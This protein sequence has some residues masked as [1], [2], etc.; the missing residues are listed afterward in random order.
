MKVLVTGGAGFIG[1]QFT[2]MALTGELGKFELV[3]VLD[4]FTY[5]GLKSNLAQFDGTANFELFVGDISNPQDVNK[6]CEGIDAVVNFAAE[7]HVDR[8]IT[9]AQEFIKTNVDGVRVLLETCRNMKIRL[10]QVSTDEVYGSIAKGSWTENFPLEPNSPYSASKASGDM[11]ARS[12]YKTFGVDVVITRCSNNYG[13]NQ[14]PEK[15]IPLFITNLLE[16]QK[17]P[18]YGR[19]N[20]IRDWLHVFDHCRAIALALTKGKSGEIYNIGGGRE[21]TNLEL[22]ETILH[23]LGFNQDQI[24]FVEDRKGHDLRYSVNWEKARIDLG[25]E[26]QVTFEKGIS[27]TISWYKENQSWW[28]PLKDK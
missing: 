14:F 9:N 3:R 5:S 12:F 11:L 25:Y 23:Q 17:V 7:S 21:L 20:N 4:K 15:V 6:Y 27:E 2:K 19:G 1:S 8:S 28:K 24:D 13:P 16:G 18:L 10:I 22:T 26:P